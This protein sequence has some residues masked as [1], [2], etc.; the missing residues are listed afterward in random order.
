MSKLPLAEDDVLIAPIGC[1]QEWKMST[2]PLCLFFLAQRNSI[3]LKT[4]ETIE[5]KLWAV[6]NTE[7]RRGIGSGPLLKIGSTSAYSTVD[8]TSFIYIFDKSPF[9]NSLPKWEP[10]VN[11]KLM[12]RWMNGCQESHSYCQRKYDYVLRIDGSG[13]INATPNVVEG[14]KL[15]DCR[16]RRIVNAEARHEYAALS[17]VWGFLSEDGSQKLSGK[18]LPAKLPQLIEDIITVTMRLGLRYLWIDRYCIGED[19][20]E[21]H[22]QITNMDSIYS[23]AEITLIMAFN[24]YSKGIPGVSHPRTPQPR[25]RL[26]QMELR[27]SPRNPRSVLRDSIW[28]RRGWT[29]QEALLSRRRITF[30][31][32]VIFTCPSSWLAES[33]PRDSVAD[34]GLE[35]IAER[36]YATWFPD[37]FEAIKCKDKIEAYTQRDFTFENDRLLGFLGVFKAFS[38]LDPPCYRVW[39]IP[40]YRR[41]KDADEIPTCNSFLGNLCWDLSRPGKRL[42]GFPSW[43]W[44]GWVAPVRFNWPFDVM[45]D[46]DVA[47]ELRDGNVIAWDD[48]MRMLADNPDLPLSTMVHLDV[49]TFEVRFKSPGGGRRVS[50]TPTYC[51]E[52][53]EEALF[54]CHLDTDSDAWKA[55]LET[56]VWTC[57]I[58]GR[59]KG[60][61]VQYA[62]VLDYEQDVAHRIGYLKFFDSHDGFPEVKKHVE[63]C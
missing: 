51:I 39:G 57:V 15:I 33:I 52:G 1:I 26:G 36:D 41:S 14:M 42:E 24:D 43:C 56:E 3:V 59:F 2:C 4:V 27:A 62:M 60:G 35:R 5:R 37:V 8:M 9:D 13:G 23:Q 55:R 63:L 12:S 18:R 30:T 6:H 53:H 49:W 47:L 20:V 29:Y 17:Y 45:Q 61:A 54:Q 31:D 25:I 58:L 40:V 50:R 34:Q 22:H 48:A 38:R 28:N 44:T 19:D 21:K 46:V 32:Q 16:A 11:F 10:Y 7:G